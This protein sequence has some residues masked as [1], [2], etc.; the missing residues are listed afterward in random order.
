MAE[1]DLHKRVSRLLHKSDESANGG[2]LQKALDALKEAS[3]LDPENARVQD[4]LVALEKRESTGDA[5]SWIQSYL[6]AGASSDG[7]KALHALRQKLLPQ[8]ESEQALELLL[9]ASKP[10]DLLDNLTGTLIFR[11]KH[12]QRLLAARFQ[13]PVTELFDQLYER[14]PE[15]LKAFSTVPLNDALWTSK[16][17]QARA[18]R[19]LFRLCIA[20]LMYDGVDHKDRLMQA[21]AQQ[22]AIAPANITKLIDMDIFEVILDCLD[23]RLDQALRSQAMLATSKVLEATKEKGEQLFGQYLASK[24]SKQTID[25]FV[26]AFSSAAAIFPMIP[27]VA[28]QLFMTDGFVQQLVP[29]LEWNFESGSQGKRSVTERDLK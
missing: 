15:S 26:V 16:D 21:V 4:A 20:K 10:L 14:G 29:N 2:D 27:V 5:L 23:I 1:D 18:Q 22:I 7:E 8:D 11:S 19:D 17:D 24:V 28:A 13:H 6:A 25:D 3:H 9:H 12:L